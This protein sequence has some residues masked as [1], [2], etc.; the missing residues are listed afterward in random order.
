MFEVLTYQLTGTDVFKIETESVTVH[1]M[2]V[3]SMFTSITY[4][5]MSSVQFNFIKYCLD[6]GIEYT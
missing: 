2:L 5:L 3:H 6:F 4:L 1:S